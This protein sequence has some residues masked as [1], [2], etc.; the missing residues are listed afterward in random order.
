MQAKLAGLGVRR[1]TL[2]LPGVLLHE[3]SPAALQESATVLAAAVPL[4]REL[5]RA[6]DV[7][8]LVHVEDDVGQAAVTGAMEAAGLVGHLPSQLPP[9]RLLFCST[10]AGKQ[11]IVRQIEPDLHVDNDDLTVDGLRRFVPQL[12]LVQEGLRECG[13]GCAPSLV[14]FFGAA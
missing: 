5:L 6:A 2:S 13:A 10:Q 8:M 11:A 12:L 7:Y 1:V 4:A 3:A 14:A 9:Q